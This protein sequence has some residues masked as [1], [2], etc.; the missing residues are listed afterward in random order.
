[1]TKTRAQQNQ[2]A[3]RNIQLG[4]SNTTVPE[5]VDERTT[6]VSATP[7]TPAQT[8]T[9][10]PPG[11]PLET[12]TSTPPS[13]I[14]DLITAETASISEEGKTIVNTII[15][16]M[17]L[18]N[19]QKDEK[20]EQ[21]QS[22]VS[23]LE[24]RIT[25]LENQVD[26]VNQYERRDTIIVSGPDLPKEE[27]NENSVD[28]VVRSIR[29]KLHININNSDINVAHRLGA[30]KS[31]NDTRPIIV[32]LQSRQTKYTIMNACVTVKPNLY[33]NESL[34]TKRRSLFK[35]VW[36]IRKQHREKFQQCYTNDG[37]IVVKLKHS[38]R[39]HI[40]TNDAGLANFLDNYPVLKEAR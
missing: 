6:Q 40:I 35:I 19:N 14:L 12:H 31:Q 29:E 23:Q 11:P 27:Q 30:K 4:K 21:L 9:Q 13:D 8:T 37:K 1:M 36:D 17:Q 34:T 26:E 32:K 24:N 3:G 2:S 18:I 7:L 15:K 38:Q 33:I 20:I 16:A 5:R 10:T 22:H 25:E 39:K 28:V